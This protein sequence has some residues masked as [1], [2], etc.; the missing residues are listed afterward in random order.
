MTSTFLLM[1]GKQ[2]LLLGLSIYMGS[3]LIGLLMPGTATKE[4]FP[5]AEI[6][7]QGKI[8]LEVPD[9][10]VK[11]IFVNN[12]GLNAIII[13]GAFSLMVFSG[14]ILIFNGLQIGY[15]IKELSEIYGLKLVFLMIG[16]HL[17]IELS[18]HLLSLYFSFLVLVKVIMPLVMSNDII[19]FSMI[20][21]KRMTLLLA[22]I[23]LITF[24]GALVEVY[25]TPLLL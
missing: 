1:R 19:D 21:I 24:L 4:Y 14:I 3:F 6:V 25:V 18:A 5:K 23:V 10:M 9:G 15:I 16:P 13:F 11:K 20:D 12:I 22:C 17:V 7:D 2:V 8:D